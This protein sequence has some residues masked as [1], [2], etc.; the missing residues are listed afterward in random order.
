MD[1]KIFAQGMAVLAAAY[2]DY[3]VKKETMKVYQEALS[4]LNPIE[5]EQA[6]WAHINLHKWFP[7]VS[8]IKE[9]V[10]R[11]RNKGRPSA[12][13]RWGQLLAMA[14]G[15][16]L[17][18]MDVPTKRALGT[19]G[20]WSVFQFTP[21]EELNFRRKEFERTYTEA[22]QEQDRDVLLGLEGHQ[23]QK[24]VTHEPTL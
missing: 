14:G 12:A 19:L 5:F 6:V 8:E 17:G 13:E 7:K 18:P 4:N 21:I 15:G 3:P 22:L 2:P 11:L 9:Q 1:K 24:Q 10:L 16:G 23:E 20:G